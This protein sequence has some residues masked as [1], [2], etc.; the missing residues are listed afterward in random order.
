MSETLKVEVRETRGK[1]HARRLRQSGAVPAILYGHG[2]ANLS[3]SIPLDQVKS[4]VRHGARVVDLAGAV[5]EKAFIRDLQWDTF[6]LEVL[7]LDLARVSADEKVEVEVVVELR[8]EAPGAKEGGVVSQVLHQVS[9]E[10]L[11]TAIP[12]KLSLSINALA[13]NQSLTAADI[14]LP[15]G[16]TLVTPGEIVV[17]QCLVPKAEEEAAPLSAE[18]AEPELIG[19]KAEDEDADES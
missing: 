14:E 9:V 18:G 1:R 12:E 2:E 5:S 17:V 10:S 4:A 3:L 15:P 11:V 16:T 13:L 6:G 8:G 7:H 19:R